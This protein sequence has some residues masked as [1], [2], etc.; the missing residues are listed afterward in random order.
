MPRAGRP[1]QPLVTDGPVSQLAGELRR[2]RDRANLTYRQLAAKTGLSA[3][4]LE[5]AAAGTRRPTWQVTRAFADACG[6]DQDMAWEL[7]AA[8]CRAAGLEPPGQPPADPP[9]PAGAASASALADMLKLLLQWAGSPSLAELNRRAGGHN[10]LPRSTVSDML[11][12]QRLPRLEL[13]LAFVRA[14]GLEED[15][16]A[17]W[18]A[19][20]ERI[21]ARESEPPPPPAS[22]LFSGAP[23]PGRSEHRRPTLTPKEAAT[24]G[25][26]QGEYKPAVLFAR[27]VVDE[28]ERLGTPRHLWEPTPILN[29]HL[30]APFITDGEQELVRRLEK[31]ADPALARAQGLIENVQGNLDKVTEDTRPIASPESG[32]NYSVA[33]AVERVGQHDETIH[34]DGAAGKYHHAR[35]RRPFRWLATWASWIEVAGFL[36]F[37]TYYLKVRLLQPW[38]DWLGWSFALT[39]VVIIL[40]QTWLVRHAARSHNHAREDSANGHR[41]G[42]YRGFTQRNWYLTGLSVT[43]AAITSGMIWRGTVALGNA[44]IGTTA[45]MI[46]G[47]AVTGLLLPT[48]A[49]LGIALDGSR[50]S[51]E[52]DGLAADLDDRLGAYLKSIGNSR[53]NLVITTAIGETLKKRTFPDICHAA[54]EAVDGV[55]RS[56][57]TMRLLIGGLSA[58]PPS[59][60]AETISVDPAGNISGYIGTSI[61]GTGTVNLGPLV[62]RQRQ[63]A[64][65][66]TQ[67][68][69]LLERIDALPPLPPLPPTLAQ[70]VTR[71]TTVGP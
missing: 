39:P 71:D 27:I 31:E 35:V 24:A 37:I 68:T 25:I 33:E 49:Y 16:A 60:T 66:E 4:T 8:A 45:V 9:D 59:R 30:A 61:P 70:H 2:M 57:G 54:Q 10:L 42:A 21:K 18:R 17:T 56:Y 22:K 3:A 7:W 29:D 50:V 13:V 5:A 20:W 1:E 69:D 23:A 15:Q 64:E 26:P 38:Q 44:S 43:A 32:S 14:C 40:G 6:G 11:H 47:T 65:I 28:H 63:L 19:T 52:R 34:Q 41:H 62:A 51:R 46:F 48:V 58:G 53:R 55:Y 12:S 36:T 67:R